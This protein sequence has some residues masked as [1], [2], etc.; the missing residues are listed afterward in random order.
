[1]TPEE[2]KAN[3]DRIRGTINASRRELLEALR[4]YLEEFKRASG[5]TVD[6]PVLET[7]AFG[8]EVQLLSRAP[9]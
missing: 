9:T 2:K 6:A 1:M 4:P 8:V 5:G 3:R 7:G